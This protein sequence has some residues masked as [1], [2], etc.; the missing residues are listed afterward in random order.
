MWTFVYFLLT[1]VP[2]IELTAIYIYI[3]RLSHAVFQILLTQKSTSPYEMSK[4]KTSKLCMVD[5]AGSERA[6]QTGATGIRLKEAASI[7]KSLRFVFD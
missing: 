1:Y 5:L 3:C 4:R 6:S 7:N 2:A